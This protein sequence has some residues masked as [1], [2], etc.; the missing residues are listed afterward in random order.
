MAEPVDLVVV[1]AGPAG[2]AAAITARARGLNVVCIDK[3]QFPRDKTCGDGLTAN[4][5]RLLERLGMSA[6]V[7]D[8]ERVPVRRIAHG[9]TA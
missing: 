9:R 1:G 4:A 6:A 5:L 8:A 2:T 7:L 3:A